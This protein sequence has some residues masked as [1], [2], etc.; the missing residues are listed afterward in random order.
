V[1]ID[2]FP[3]SKELTLGL[4]GDYNQ[5]SGDAP[6]Y[7]RPFVTLRGVAAMRYQG[8][9]VT[10]GEAEVRWQCWQR[11]SLVGFGGVG[12]AKNDRAANERNQTVHTY[13]IGMRYLI[14]R[15]FGLHMGLDVAFGPDQPVF[16]IQFGSAWARP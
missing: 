12:T 6:F 16:Y 15:K 14:A 2:Y 4:R 13:G 5:I 11:F 3:L 8:T 7:M 10:Q 1:L 9:S